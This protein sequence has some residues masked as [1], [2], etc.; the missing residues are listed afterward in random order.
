MGLGWELK[1]PPR[2]LY[3]LNM[4][5][6]TGPCMGESRGVMTALSPNPDNSPLKLGVKL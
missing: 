5:S 6:D 2:M 1:L 3:G 4:S